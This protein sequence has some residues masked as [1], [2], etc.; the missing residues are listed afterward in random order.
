MKTLHSNAWKY[1]GVIGTWHV[2][3]SIRKNFDPE[4]KLVYRARYIYDDGSYKFFDPISPSKHVKLDFNSLK[5]DDFKP[6]DYD[7][8]EKNTLQRLT[9]YS[10][11]VNSM[12][13]LTPNP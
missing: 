12:T 6:R 3:Q 1:V 11:R 10:T 4:L 9:A 8:F 7:R 5:L 2:F 13:Q